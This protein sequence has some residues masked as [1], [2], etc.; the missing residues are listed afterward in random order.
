M[1]LVIESVTLPVDKPKEEVTAQVVPIKNVEPTPTSP[2]TVSTT[3]VIDKKKPSKKTAKAGKNE[4]TVEPMDVAT[5]PVVSVEPEAVATKSEPLVA[6]QPSIPI[7]A[8]AEQKAPAAEAVATP[9]TEAVVEK[10]NL[11][12]GKGKKNKKE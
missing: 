8:T 7:Q 10:A 4:V 5:P 11:K 9:Q 3:D 6:D 2:S 12:K 1:F